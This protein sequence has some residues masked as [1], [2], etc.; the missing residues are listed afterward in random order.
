[1]TAAFTARFPA[2]GSAIDSAS[3][4]IH[5]SRRK[6]EPFEKFARRAEK[7][8]TRLDDDEYDEFKRI[9]AQHLLDGMVDGDIEL[10]VKERVENRLEAL[11]K[12]TRGS[13]GKRILADTCTFGEVHSLISWTF[14]LDSS[15]L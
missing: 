8:P 10:R 5:F 3:K 2:T 4:V 12:L 7:F 1:M 13:G 11:G 6:G 9:M 14:V 15:N